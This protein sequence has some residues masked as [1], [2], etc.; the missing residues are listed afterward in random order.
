MAARSVHVAWQP[1]RRRERRT[2]P[3]S[4]RCMTAI[5]TFQIA[6]ALTASFMLDPPEGPEPVEPKRRRPPIVR[7]VVVSKRRSAYT[8]PVR[9][10]QVLIHR[11][12][13]VFSCVSL[14]WWPAEKEDYGDRFADGSGLW[15]NA[16][17][18]T[19][20]FS[21]PLL[22]AAM[23]A[24][25]PTILRVGGSLAD[26]V[27]Y[28]V[29]GRRWN[30]PPFTRDDR[31]RIGFRGG[32]L[33]WARWLETLDFC[34]SVGCQVYFTVSAL[35][36]RRRAE[37]AEGTLCRKLLPADRPA[38]CT[39]YSGGW[40]TSNLRAFLAATAATGK[41]PSA[42]ALGNELAGPR[43][44]EA[45]ISAQEYASDLRRLAALARRYWPSKPPLLVAPDS[46]LDERWLSDM[47][48]QL[49]P[50]TTGAAE[51]EGAGGDLTGGTTA[52]RAAG[53]GATA[54]SGN[55]LDV[56]VSHHMC[57]SPL[58]AKLCARA[59]RT[60]EASPRCGWTG[61][62]SEL[63]T[64]RRLLPSCWSRVSLTWP[65]R[66]SRQRRASWPTQAAAERA[67]TPPTSPHCDV[68]AL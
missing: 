3:L 19:T 11:L 46:N 40:D 17:V 37:C 32:C 12:Q 24:L 9:V 47:L 66:G 13:N 2:F 35:Q 61:T 48:R 22:R 58:P 4:C 27:T 26:L 43:G 36:G 23:R 44:I 6:A 49:Y 56:L 14:D 51:G 64:R 15:S 60:C 55:A 38:C 68:G 8:V 42:L 65:R 45:H 33:P 31:R 34:A 21:D 52:G 10:D 63:A 62:P 16:S 67:C 39:N 5:V 41:R 1:S 25:A 30:C 57:E 59:S 28:E 18:L 20:N 53:A 50:N 7:P 29:P 54:S